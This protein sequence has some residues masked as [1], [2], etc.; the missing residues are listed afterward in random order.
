M[1]KV[2]FEIQF[3]SNMWWFKV[4]TLQ[5]DEFEENKNKSSV[6]LLIVLPGDCFSA[7]LQNKWAV[8]LYLRKVCKGVDMV[9]PK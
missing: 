4:E 1:C 2:K 5:T 3:S 6:L 7:A 9:I 8:L